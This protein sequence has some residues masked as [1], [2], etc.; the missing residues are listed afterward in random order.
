MRGR[1]KAT[2]ELTETERDELRALALRRKTAQATALRA[3]I[4][5]ACAEGLENNAVAKRLSVTKQTVSKWR[6]RFVWTAGRAAVRCPAHDR[7]RACGGGRRQDAGVHA[8]GRHALEHAPDGA[9][10][11]H[12]RQCGVPDLAGLRAAA[13]SSRDLQAVHRSDVRGEGARHRGSVQEP[14][15]DDDGAVRGREEP[16]SGA[17]PNAAD[18]A[19]DPRAVRAAH[20]RL[21][22]PRNDHVVRSTGR[23][24]WQNHRRDA[25]PAP[26]QRVPAVP[27]HDRGPTCRRCST[28]IS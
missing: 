8:P 27:A 22:A 4:V 6:G 5:L 21:C 1:P 26:Q 7:R 19:S 12:D 11:G 2:L 24:Y 9:R 15:A 23:R 18:A 17:R 16:D 28:S 14:A 3:R 25:S 10:D 20:A 13:A